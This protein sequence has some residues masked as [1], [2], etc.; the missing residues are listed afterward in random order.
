M[1][2]DLSTGRRFYAN[3]GIL[4]LNPDDLTEL[5]E[6]YDGVVDGGSE[7]YPEPFTR[8]ERREIAT[9]MIEAWRRW[10]ELGPD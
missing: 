3:C 5:C 7:G 1:H 8:G 10:A 4:G 6:G 2:W 9:R